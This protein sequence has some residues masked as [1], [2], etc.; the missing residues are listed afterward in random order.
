MRKKELIK[1]LNEL[2]KGSREYHEKNDS[3]AGA[4]GYLERGIELIIEDVEK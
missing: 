1:K 2:L 3:Y 4:F